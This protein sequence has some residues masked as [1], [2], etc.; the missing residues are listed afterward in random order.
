MG[1]L[2]AF[3]R[4]V[5]DMTVT[6]ANLHCLEHLDDDEEHEHDH[7]EVEVDHGGSVEERD[8]ISTNEDDGGPSELLQNFRSKFLGQKF[9]RLISIFRW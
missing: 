6:I 3:S 9:G 7:D 2:T 5:L 1:F 8:M 4:V